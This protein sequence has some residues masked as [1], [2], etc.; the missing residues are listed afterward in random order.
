MY[1]ANRN[2]C[3]YD[4]STKVDIFSRFF[5]YICIMFFFLFDRDQDR[6]RW[7]RWTT[8]MIHVYREKLPADKFIRKYTACIIFL[9]YWL[10]YSVKDASKLRKKSE[11]VWRLCLHCAA[12]CSNEFPRTFNNESCLIAALN[13]IRYSLPALKA[14]LI[15]LISF[16]YS[17]K[18]EGFAYGLHFVLLI[19]PLCAPASFASYAPPGIM[20]STYRMQGNKNNQV[21]LKKNTFQLFSSFQS[22]TKL[23]MNE[24][25]KKSKI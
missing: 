24:L 25:Y 3:F 18:W 14:L 22:S 7:M 20:N 21:S 11:Y 12:V 8:V 15:Q 16:S 9:I 2:R 23:S 4:V 6:Y 5:Y 13:S 17:F 19:A 10:S 1:N